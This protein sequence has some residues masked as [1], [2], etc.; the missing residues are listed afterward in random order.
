MSAAPPACQW[1]VRVSPSFWTAMM[2]GKSMLAVWLALPQARFHPHPSIGGQMEMW[3]GSGRPCQLHPLRL[4]L[5]REGRPVCSLNCKL[6]EKGPETHRNLTPPEIWVLLWERSTA[7]PTCRAADPRL[8]WEAWGGSAC[9]H[10]LCLCCCSVLVRECRAFWGERVY[11]I[12]VIM[13]NNS[14]RTLTEFTVFSIKSVG[15][16][17]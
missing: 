10:L 2:Q 9:K 4:R 7:L 17:K 11:C 16:W 3:I 14:A 15:L 12:A 13:V 6:S 8:V 5:L 1:L